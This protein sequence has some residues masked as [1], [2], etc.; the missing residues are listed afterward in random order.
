M[1]LVIVLLVIGFILVGA[2]VLLPGG[3]LGILALVLFII[4]TSIAATSYGS[5]AGLL[6]FASAFIGS[7]ITFF[8]MFKWVAVSPKGGGLRLDAAIQGH[9]TSQ[10]V[11]PAL[12]GQN[13]I[14]STKMAPDG[15][16]SV[17]DQDL[18]AHSEDGF[19]EIGTQVTI[20]AIRHG[21]LVVRKTV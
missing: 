6:T 15:L 5:N 20:H 13:G 11:D 12:V 21:N 1:T 2:E 10:S 16:I 3:I 8:S 4:A 14:A 19:L 9:A 7:I 18:Q 17:G